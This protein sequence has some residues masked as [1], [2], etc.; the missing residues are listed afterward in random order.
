MS[1]STLPVLPPAAQ[2]ALRA[3]NR[4][5]AVALVRQATGLGQRDA[6]L[7]VARHIEHCPTL[8][9]PRLRLDRATLAW[10]ALAG[11]MACALYLVLKQG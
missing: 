9:A 5:V 2:S 10:A 11:A 8:Y 7:L 1:D 6:T 3:G 4:R